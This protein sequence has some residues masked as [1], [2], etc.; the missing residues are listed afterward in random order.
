MTRSLSR[1]GLSLIA[2]VTVFCAL[3][4]VLVM[5]YQTLWRGTSRNLFSIQ[6]DRELI[7]LARSSLAE[8][9]YLLQ[10]DLDSSKQ[11]WFDWCTTPYPAP[12]EQFTPALTQNNAT[13]M[14]TNPEFL[15]YTSEN[16][17]V[18]RIQGVSAD[19]AG[20]AQGIIEMEVSVKVIRQSPRHEASLTL[21][22]RRYFWLADAHGPFE[23]GGRRVE[24]SPTPVATAFK[25]VRP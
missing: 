20:T 3:L 13:A 21:M 7:N 16:V 25:E 2:M 6:E 12:E 24:V 17:K 9:L 15:A 8:A 1:R 18:R 10:D 4:A 5:A 22:E 19:G 23:F 11:K 14:S